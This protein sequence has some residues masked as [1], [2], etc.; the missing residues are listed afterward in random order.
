MKKNMGSA[1]QAIRLLVAAIILVMYFSNIITGTIG[2]ILLALA[3]VFVVT[4]FAGFCP[5]YSL[6]GINTCEVKK[7][8]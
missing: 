7:A 1:D 6:L 3:G 2:I 8:R 5:L 4:S